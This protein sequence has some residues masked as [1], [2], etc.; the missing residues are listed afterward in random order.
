MRWLCLTKKWGRCRRQC[1]RVRTW[2]WHLPESVCTNF[3]AKCE[4]VY[5]HHEHDDLA[6]T[7]QNFFWSQSAWY[8]FPNSRQNYMTKEFKLC[9]SCCADCAGCKTWNSFLLFFVVIV[10]L[11]FMSHWI[12]LAYFWSSPA[13]M[14]RL[15]CFSCKPSYPSHWYHCWSCS[16]KVLQLFFQD[17][18][19][20]CQ[21]FDSNLS[22]NSKQY[23]MF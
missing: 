6:A 23:S 21:R 22:R 2:N 1:E 9:K 10:D 11:H 18:R 3:W 15:F 14:Q 17:Q 13:T 20:L 8:V 5:K 16:D 19:Q 7:P 12:T 4:D